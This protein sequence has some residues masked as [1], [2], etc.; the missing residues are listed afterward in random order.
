MLSFTT[1]YDIHHSAMHHSVY[2]STGCCIVVCLCAVAGAFA[3]LLAR[4]G[5]SLHQRLT[6]HF[7]CAASCCNTTTR[8]RSI[9]SNQPLFYSR[10]C[11]CIVQCS[12]R[13]PGLPTA[14]R[15]STQVAAARQVE[16]PQPCCCHARLFDTACRNCRDILQVFKKMAHTMEVTTRLPASRRRCPVCMALLLHS[17]AHEPVDGAAEHRT[18]WGH[19]RA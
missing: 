9:T 15:V 16:K 2:C 3:R 11:I 17:S 7:H 4:F 18:P 5:G 10:T 13:L 8:M 1:T 6:T 12:L 14:L 19:R